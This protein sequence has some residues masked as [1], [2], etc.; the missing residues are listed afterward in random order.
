MAH[1]GCAVTTHTL[2]EQ[3]LQ[4]PFPHY[5]GHNSKLL[6][7]KKRSNMSEPFLLLKDPDLGRDALLKI[8]LNK[9]MSCFGAPGIAGLL[10]GSRTG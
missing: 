3:L 2:Y 5:V 10:S 8:R 1:T 9:C 7:T 6:I 4:D